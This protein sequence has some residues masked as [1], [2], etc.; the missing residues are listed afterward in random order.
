[1]RDLII[2]RIKAS[3]CYRKLYEAGEQTPILSLMLNDELLGY[4]DFCMSHQ[5]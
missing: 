1:M 4:Y 2:D 3:K 5:G